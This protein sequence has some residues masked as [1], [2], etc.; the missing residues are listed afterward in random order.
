MWDAMT[1][2]EVPLAEPILRTA[3]VYLLVLLLIRVIG[4]RSL[5]E[6]SMFDIV[7]VLLLA[8]IASSSAI[9]ADDSVSASAASALTLVVLSSA[10]NPLVHRSPAA[11]SILQGNAEEVIRDGQMV[12]GVL[13]RLG[14]S[15]SE[16]DHAIRGQHGDDVSE[17]DHAEL[18]P[19]GKLVVTLKHDEQ[20]A[21]KA[22]VAALAGQIAELKRLLADRG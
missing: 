17:I 21:T 20:S 16:L 3:A 10:V 2:L 9:G 7:V 19:S 4:K 14:I 6:M 8:D 13:R 15:R 12:E 5:G 11:A 18:T 22:D 1:D